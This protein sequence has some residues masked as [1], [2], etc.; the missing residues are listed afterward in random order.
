MNTRTLLSPL[1]SAWIFLGILFALL[2]DRTVGQNAEYR[3]RVGFRARVTPFTQGYYPQ[4]SATLD[5]AQTLTTAAYSSAQGY[6]Y[7]DSQIAD[8]EAGKEYDLQASVPIQSNGVDPTWVSARLEFDTKPGVIV[9]VNGLPAQGAVLLSTDPFATIAVYSSKWASGSPFD[10][11][12]PTTDNVAWT[13]PL[14]GLPSGLWAG[15]LTIRKDNVPSV[16]TPAIL[17]YFQPDTTEIDVVYSGSNL[18]QIKTPNWLVDIATAGVASGFE[19]RLYSAGSFGAT[20]VS[21]LYPINSGTQP[22]ITYAI[23]NVSA[24]G[25]TRLQ[26][27]RIVGTETFQSQVA[28]N[29][30]GTRYTQAVSRNTATPVV[31][32][33][34]DSTIT[35]N[36]R[37]MVVNE[38]DALGA[39][40]G[41]YQLTGQTLETDATG[42][43]KEV[44]TQRIDDPDGKKYTQSFEYYANSSDKVTYRKLKWQKDVNGHWARFDY[45][46]DSSNRKGLVQSIY[47]PWLDSPSRPEDATP[48]TGL[49]TS[50]DYFT[51]AFSGNDPLLSMLGRPTLVQRSINNVVVDKTTHDYAA[52]TRNGKS[53]IVQTTKEYYGPNSTDALT[54]VRKFY[55]PTQSTAL[56]RY[57]N[58]PFSNTEPGGTRKSWRYELGT[59]NPVSKVFTAGA[60]NNWR[61]LTLLG[62]SLASSGGQLVQSFG[63]GSESQVDDIYLLP[64]ESLMEVAVLDNEARVVHTETWV[65]IGSPSANNVTFAQFE[66][67]HWTDSTFDVL[68]NLTSRRT[69]RGESYDA[70]YPTPGFLG[71]ETDATGVQTEYFYDGSLGLLNKSIRRGVAASGSFPAVN[72][73][74]NLFTRNWHNQ[75][76]HQ[77]T[78]SANEVLYADYKYDQGGQ[79]V[80]TRDVNGVINKYSLE[81]EGAN[82]WHTVF[83]EQIIDR[84]GAT[85]SVVSETV[86]TRAR[87]AKIKSITGSG[88]INKYFDYAIL[89]G[90]DS[91]KF[92]RTESIGSIGSPRYLK[93]TTDWL[94]RT[95]SVTTPAAGGI[96]AIT[97]STYY[98]PVSG[99]PVRQ[100]SPGSADTL[101]SYDGLG[102]LKQKG[103]DMNGD[104]QLTPASADR[105]QEFQSRMIKDG[106][107]WWHQSQAFTYPENNSATRLVTSRKRE[108]VTGF[109]G[110]LV[111]E[112][113]QWGA[114]PVPAPD[115]ANFAG[116]PP[117]VR[118][119][120]SVNR[121]TLT[122]EIRTLSPSVGNP[123][124]AVSYGGLLMFKTNI[125]GVVAAYRYDHFNRLTNSVDFSGNSDTN[126]GPVTLT[127]ATEY[128]SGMN[129]I[130]R[131]WSQNTNGALVAVAEYD[132]YPNGPVRSIRNADGKYVRYA[133]NSREQ[134]AYE[135]GDATRPAKY[136]YDGY[137]QLQQLQTFRS[138]SQWQGATFPSDFATQGDTTTWGYDES[139]GLPVSKQDAQHTAANPRQLSFGYNGLNQLITTKLAR[140]VVITNSYNPLTGELARR[141]YSDST[142]WITNTYGRIGQLTQ[143]GDAAG[144]HTFSYR[145][146]EDY[147][148]AEEQL[149]S[150]FYGQNLRLRSKFD[151]YR[152]KVGYTLGI[153]S[154]A[155]AAFTSTSLDITDSLDFATS[156]L[157][158]IQSITQN[159]ARTKTFGYGYLGQS[160]MLSTT[161]AP[162]G[163]ASF[164]QT[165]KYEPY[166]ALLR[167]LDNKTS[168]PTQSYNTYAFQR[169]SLGQV[170]NETQT[171]L[172][173]S[174]YGAGVGL[175]T[176]Y[177][178]N[179]RGELVEA[180]TRSTDGFIEYANRYFGASYDHAGNRLS[181]TAK[182]A[183]GTAAPETYSP[184]SLNQYD[185]RSHKNFTFAP[186][187]A[188]PAATV[189]VN[190]AGSASTVVTRKTGDGAFVA[191]T[192]TSNP[193]TPLASWAITTVNGVQTKS[194]AVDWRPATETFVYDKD[195]NLTS[196]A[197]F[198][199]TYDAENRLTVVSNKVSSL[200]T[201]K[202]FVYDSMNRRVEE[203]LYQNAGLVQTRRYVYDGFLCLAKIDVSGTTRT[204]S[205]TYTW[206]PD[207]S[208]TVGGAGGMGGLLLVDSGA[209]AQ[210]LPA[211]DGR[212]N[213][214]LLLDAL[215]HDAAT[216]ANN[217]KASFEWGPNGEMI[218]FTGNANLIP[219]RWQTKWSLDFETPNEAF[220]FKLYDFGQRYY[221]PELG[222]FINR[223]PQQE[224]GGANLYMYAGNSPVMKGDRLGLDPYLQPYHGVDGARM[225]PFSNG[226]AGSQLVAISAGNSSASAGNPTFQSY[227][228]GFQASLGHWDLFAYGKLTLRSDGAIAIEWG[229]SGTPREFRNRERDL[230]PSGNNDGLDFLENLTS[231]LVGLSPNSDAQPPGD[232]GP[233][234]SGPSSPSKKPPLRVKS[235]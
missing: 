99:L 203:R 115:S 169:D 216:P 93:T 86:I 39:Q 193:N 183:N 157:N 58:L 44:V 176:S 207:S 28:L 63:T 100:T 97:V 199:Y 175:K 208:G 178:H 224:S 220:A 43:K 57:R 19:V 163:T 111:A 35:G 128:V 147:G 149:D 146:T 52:T 61:H 121:S 181:D 91:G 154:S 96:G 105:I 155:T 77:E 10:A 71:I 116:T 143:V 148:L 38:K 102:A 161:T 214:T 217:I 206:G 40:V 168:G 195:G 218:A 172:L 226:G 1:R 227:G 205:Q 120:V 156:R 65:Y 83:R 185:S 24:T 165:R 122:G 3:I 98:D 138:G 60:G 101:Y 212:G 201:R 55:S 191:Q 144:T 184:N 69:S 2:P 234:K 232:S 104:G 41:K 159:G 47:E 56:A 64:N 106:T 219:F 6:L 186:D 8:L 131:S 5:S 118:T 29:T 196:D 130:L 151:A 23:Q 68:G 94:D 34:E 167:S 145:T 114:N 231:S 46:N 108:R 62:N 95:L 233:N 73:A 170:L 222:R 190:V 11:S 140:G 22:T 16:I 80:E 166:R 109:T 213:V 225:V 66:R 150:T 198:A 31:T 223:D 27:K 79:L 85:D 194:Q 202:E 25:E 123:S 37:I 117:Y 7:T 59:W 235:A 20:K 137:G 174:G 89:T 152:R 42:Y 32:K 12:I 76:S 53:V 36:T 87:D 204:L 124:V 187:T 139:T 209:S 135:W 75:L 153:A 171:G 221:S 103:L 125:T 84:Q 67:V 180:I 129:R 17:N 74:T 132:Y 49:V 113:Y 15:A 81:T 136:L 141:S 179:S 18:R 134:V 158:S 13:M 197:V 182:Q 133:Y 51:A 119:L 229:A 210:Y 30:A 200:K 230:N 4:F 82:T 160:E 162:I 142:P 33:Q 50:F 211:Y 188:A 70:S 9:C 54:T 88:V 72:A 48:T 107:D 78:R 112:E 45:W 92:R 14:G 21:G 26:I 90:A 126:L 192:T 177:T 127:N 110:N 173:F 215:N 228:F 189:A 164:V